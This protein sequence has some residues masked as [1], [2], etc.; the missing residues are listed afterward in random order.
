MKYLHYVCGLMLFAL[1]SC[2]KEFTIEG[3]TPDPPTPVDAV[4]TFDGAPG[5]CATAVVGGTYETGRPLD[6]LNRVTILVTVTVPGNYNIST[7]SANGISFAG[8]GTF[9]N[10]G[11]QSVVLYGAGTPLAAVDAVFTPTSNGCSFTVT[12]QPG[13]NSTPVYQAMFDGVLKTFSNSAA[14]IL[15][16]DTLLLTGLA[17]AGGSESMEIF[18]IGSTTIAPG[19]Y[20]VEGVLPGAPFTEALYTTSSL[21]TWYINSTAPTP[22]SNPFSVTITAVTSTHVSGIFSGGLYDSGGSATEMMVTNGQ[23]LLEIQ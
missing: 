14:A 13:T 4:F 9:A 17:V 20:E 10:T 11:P 1:V 16:N 12:T 15:S 6:N 7:N 19:V 18:V 3:F 8:T 21:E 22:Q 2:Q 5:N 23:F